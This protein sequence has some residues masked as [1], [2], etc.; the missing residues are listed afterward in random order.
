MSFI[1]LTKSVKFKKNGWMTWHSKTI[2]V[3]FS[4]FNGSE[5]TWLFIISTSSI[6]CIYAKSLWDVFL[7]LNYM[8]M[9]NDR[10]QWLNIK[11]KINSV[12][13]SLSI[14]IICDWP[15][16]SQDAFEIVRHGE[17][18]DPWNIAWSPVNL[19]NIFTSAF[20]W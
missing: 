20:S 2:E 17:T 13:L 16:Q 7:N 4:C 8:A 12:I 3:F 14:N 10:W 19:S 15:R 18:F 11:N 9:V 1:C 5:A 6:I